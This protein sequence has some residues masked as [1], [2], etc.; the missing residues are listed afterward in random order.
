MKIIH[1]ML[2]GC[3]PDSLEGSEDQ[4]PEFVSD[5]LSSLFS[6]GSEPGP[7]SDDG[8]RE[9]TEAE[10]GDET[11]PEDLL[12]HLA[13]FF[14]GPDGADEQGLGDAPAPV[15]EDDVVSPRAVSLS[16]FAMFV[17]NLVSDLGLV[18]RELTLP[19]VSELCDR[20]AADIQGKADAD[21]DEPR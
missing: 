13:R 17:V 8:G 3:A 9:N 16:I 15:E 12:S 5:F 10:G 11:S 6:G 14:G 7:K 4:V 1:V 18:R 2:S 20:V 21:G 19:V